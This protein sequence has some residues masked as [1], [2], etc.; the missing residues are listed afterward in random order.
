MDNGYFS[1]DYA[2]TVNLFKLENGEALPSL[3]DFESEIPV[4]FRMSHHFTFLE[5][6]AQ[7]QLQK[8][9]G[10]EATSAIMEYL[11]VQN[12]KLDLLLNHALAQE[13]EKQNKYTTHSLGGSRFTVTFEQEPI[14][15]DQ[16]RIKLFL[17]DPAYAVYAYAQVTAVE[18][19][20]DA[21]LVTFE[22]CRIL[23]ADEDKLIRAALHQQQKML[24]QR[25][26]DRKNT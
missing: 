6:R 13:I 9:H 24:R 14:V 21:Y 1:V 3:E 10:V 12:E 2:A 17:V 5:S 23:E 18:P 7:Q 11:S 25:A 8:L 26:E 15:D 4:P 19:N 22:Y 16:Y 20:E